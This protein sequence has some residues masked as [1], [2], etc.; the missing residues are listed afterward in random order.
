MKKQII[1]LIIY[2]L[3]VG[4][5]LYTMAVNQSL[6]TPHSWMFLMCGS[7]CVLFKGVAQHSEQTES[8][9]PKF[10]FQPWIFRKV[11]SYRYV[12]DLLCSVIVVN[13]SKW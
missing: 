1:I 12:K 11:L 6:L 7:S 8:F 2:R 4:V 13:G 9:G 10:H 3:K 5:L